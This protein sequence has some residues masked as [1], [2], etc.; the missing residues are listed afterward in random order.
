MKNFEKMRSTSK[1]GGQ[2]ITSATSPKVR[3]ANSSFG[4]SPG[5]RVTQPSF[6]FLNKESKSNVA[7]GG[8]KL[9]LK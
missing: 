4:L 9:I 8:K 2:T 7:I 5:G 3:N 1:P 6:S